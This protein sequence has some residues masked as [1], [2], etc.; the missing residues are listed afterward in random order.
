[1]NRPEALEAASK[2]VAELAP[3]TNARGYADGS[4]RPAERV[5]LVLRVADWFLADEA[6]IAAAVDR[7]KAAN[8]GALRA[9]VD[10]FKSEGK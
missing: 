3:T 10:L 8:P 4:L 1:M 7:V 5:E 6:S 9:L 2:V